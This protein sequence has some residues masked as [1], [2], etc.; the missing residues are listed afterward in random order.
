MHVLVSDTSILIDL[1]RGHLLESAFQLPF[2]FSVSDLLYKRE[3]RN[4]NGKQLQ[5]LGL[6]VLELDAGDVSQALV[7]RKE[8]PAL[9]LPD[10]FALTLAY[11]HNWV[12]LTGDRK[13]EKLA[14]Q[15]KIDCHSVLWVID[16]MYQLQIADQEILYAGLSK[17]SNHPRCRLPHSE[18]KSRLQLFEINHGAA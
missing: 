7:F 11:K 17:L 13:L 4:C 18:I 1:E 14:Y 2:N 12:L 3:L 15:E 9:S 8:E 10:T 6:K 5:R 16:Q